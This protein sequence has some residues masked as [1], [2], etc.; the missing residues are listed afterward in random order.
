M[1]SYDPLLRNPATV[2]LKTSY[3]AKGGVA[4]TYYLRHISFSYLTD[5]F[6]SFTVAAKQSNIHIIFKDSL[7][8]FYIP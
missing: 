7:I 1:M 2:P 8:F 6:L 3:D 5:F 4:N